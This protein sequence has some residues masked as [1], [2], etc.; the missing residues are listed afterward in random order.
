MSAADENLTTEIELLPDGRICVF[1]AS[2]EVLELIDDV[3][4]GSDEALRR[5]LIA[6]RR[7]MAAGRIDVKNFTE[8]NHA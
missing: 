5:R 6:I 7:H 8:A 1:G 3:Q 2:L 4:G